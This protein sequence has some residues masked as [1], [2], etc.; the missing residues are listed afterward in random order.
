MSTVTIKFKSELEE[1]IIKPFR[2]KIRQEIIDTSAKI[3]NKEPSAI[4]VDFEPWGTPSPQNAPD[5]LLKAETSL[6]RRHLIK[7]WGKQC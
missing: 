3:L 6:A 2:K 5:I 7:A 1:T 4:I